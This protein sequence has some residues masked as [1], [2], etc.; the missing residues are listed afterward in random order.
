MNFSVKN[1]KRSFYNFLSTVLAFI[2]CRVSGFLYFTLTCVVQLSKQLDGKF[3]III[4]VQLS[5]G[6]RYAHCL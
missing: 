5:D 6:H 2:N 1:L 4:V 3:R